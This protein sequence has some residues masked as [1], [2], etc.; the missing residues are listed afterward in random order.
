MAVIP[1]SASLRST[2]FLPSMRG[3]APSTAHGCSGTE[4]C[5]TVGVRA[6]IHKPAEEAAQGCCR[7]AS[8]ATLLLAAAGS[9]A[10]LGDWTGKALAIPTSAVAGRVPGL[11]VPDENGLRTYKRPEGK[12]GGHG[13]GW[14]ELIPYSFKVSGTW[15]EV[16]VS[17]ADLGGTEIDLRFQSKPEGNL[18]VVV[19]PV[20]R[21]S[22]R[23]GNNVRIEDIGTPER[24]IYAFG[25]E[26]TGSNVEGKVKDMAV[27]QYDGL[28]YYQYELEPHILVSA[29]ATGN[30]LYIITVS[31]NGRQWK[32]YSDS[33]REIASS[34]RVG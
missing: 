7:R 32:K 6:S 24:V 18:S 23:L 13:V 12:S 10:L 15:E 28:T 26:L 22:D 3:Q 31:A 21:F 16:P 4:Q 17:I 5:F 30:R 2:D 8:I 19:A 1:K 33:L 25:P 11:S 34:F 27:V 14:S 9:S 29:T 20:L